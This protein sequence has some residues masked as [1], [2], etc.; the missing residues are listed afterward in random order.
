MFP[1]VHILWAFGPQGL[2]ELGKFLW[3]NFCKVVSFP[4]PTKKGDL[5]K[6]A[7]RKLFLVRPILRKPTFFVEVEASYCKYIP[8]WLKRGSAQFND[9]LF[10]LLILNIYLTSP[11]LHQRLMHDTA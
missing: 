8:G 4:S 5:Q 7:F 3:A 10:G 9:L 2:L 1:Y 6:W 11:D